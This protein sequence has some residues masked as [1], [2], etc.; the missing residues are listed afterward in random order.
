MGMS[1]VAKIIVVN[2]V[3]LSKY[4]TILLMKQ[5]LSLY[6]TLS[7]MSRLVGKD[8]FSTHIGSL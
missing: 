2:V 3:R 1:Y 4:G 7:K 6:E 5:L 8:T